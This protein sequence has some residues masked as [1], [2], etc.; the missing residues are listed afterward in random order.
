MRSASLRSTL[1]SAALA[2]A[3]CGESTPADAPAPA[4]APA[5]DTTAPDFAGKADGDLT[6]RSM[7]RLEGS[8]T[9][10]IA[11]AGE[12][13][14]YRFRAF[15]GT[16]VRVTLRSPDG[17][18]DPMLSVLGPIPSAP[19]A[20]A[21]FNDDATD[22]SF[23]SAIE[24]TA[25][26]FGAYQIVVGT[27]GIHKLG[28]QTAGKLA[29][30]FTC[31]E[32][33]SQ[34]QIPLTTLFEGVDPAT[35][36]ALLSDAVPALFTDP[37]TAAAVLAQASG[38]INGTADGPFPVAPLSA[39]GTAQALFE[40]PAE[41]VPPPQP[42]TFELETLLTKGCNPVRGTVEPLHPSLPASLT[43]GWPT[44]WSIDDCALQRGQDF[45]NVLNN[46]ALDNGSKVVSSTANYESVEDV[47]VALID[48]GHHVVV[49]NNRYLANFLGL[50][51]NGASVIA[52]VWLDTGIA[53][54]RG[55]LTIPAGHS[56]HT[57][58]VSGP[59]IN[60]SLMY[61]MGT[62]GGT[63]WRVQG[64]S[65]RPDWA[66]ETTLYTYDSAVEPDTVV[67]M[68][69]TAARLRRVWAERG[70]GLPVNGYG[71]LGVCNDSTAVL[72]Y[73]AEETITLFPLT[74]PPVEGAPAG[75]VDQI[76]SK[77][78]SDTQ[79]FEDADAIRRILASMPNV[80]D[81]VPHLKAQL[82][83]VRSTGDR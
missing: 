4:P 13:V 7:G 43:R 83:S 29:L 26:G 54:D 78:P 5:K 21:A 11:L 68:M 20:V 22:D 38:V 70:A 15:A 73:S 75:I 81:Q 19:D 44:D 34:P 51:Y 10:T 57:I 72:E 62:S 18:L 45:A 30:E 82:D 63:S 41:E 31:L 24:L 56:H 2:C 69:T 33:C 60:T 52:P 64:A 1:I 48:S 46:L 37:T 58:H 42:L 6:I 55:S 14:S 79:G 28:Q 35:L 40:A 39:L 59:L 16:K 9:R 47:F 66:G 25:D 67:A 61:Y 17:D 32:G 23:D 8:E 76:L 53:T 80:E 49:E 50:N 65:L 36:Q 77:L 74:S 12:P 71:R 3:A 27:Y